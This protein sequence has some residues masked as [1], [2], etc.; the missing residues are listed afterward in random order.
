MDGKEAVS[1][2]NFNVQYP[3]NIPL[4]EREWVVVGVVPANR[5]TSVYGEGAAGKSLL[6]IELALCVQE[7]VP[8]L[9]K[10]VKQCNVLYIDFEED[11]LEFRRRIGGLAAGH[12]MRTLPTV[13]YIEADFLLTP[14]SGDGLFD[15]INEL[16]IG[17]LIIDTMGY[18][19]AADLDKGQD[20]IASM[21]V[22][23]ALLDTDTEVAVVVGDHEPKYSATEI[24]SAYKRN[25][26]RSQFRLSLDDSGRRRFKR[27]K[28]NYTT[29]DE[30][31]LFN[32][33][34]DP[35]GTIRI[36]DVEGGDELSTHPI[37]DYLRDHPFITVKDAEI[38]LKLK[39]AHRQIKRLVVEGL[40][41][42]DGKDGR[43][44]KYVLAPPKAEDAPSYTWILP[45][46][47]DDW[48][49]GAQVCD[50]S[51]APAKEV[52]QALTDAARAGVVERYPDIAVDTVR[53]TTVKWR[54]E[55]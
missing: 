21:R 52:K 38:K 34:F 37:I 11:A 9:G 30:T 22:L 27:T 2:N 44:V 41:V 48:Q 32:Y 24:G 23:Q 18:A 31:I 26:V 39:V 4:V 12:G 50:Q 14:R 29:T 28:G 25:A 10:E 33:V 35:D 36:E 19:F 6:L 55:D 7:G 49:T 45:Y 54:L 16:E 17:L 46:L 8:F 53:H 42:A 1:I 15:L 47:T 20:A 43:A 13:G 40:I 5:I 51:T 3:A